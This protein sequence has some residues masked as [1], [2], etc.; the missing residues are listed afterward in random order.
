MQGSGA[1][2]CCILILE[3]LPFIAPSLQT[4]RAIWLVMVLAMLVGGGWEGREG[5]GSSNPTAVPCLCQC[6]SAVGQAWEPPAEVE[7]HACVLGARAG[8]STEG[9]AETVSA[10]VVTSRWRIPGGV[11]NG[12]LICR[13]ALADLHFG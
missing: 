2:L 4:L 8:L 12:D 3:G 7:G 6:S 5:S 9:H 10:E 11:E 13:V 1:V